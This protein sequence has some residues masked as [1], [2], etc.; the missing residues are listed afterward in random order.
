VVTTGG[1]WRIRKREK[2]PFLEVFR[3]EETGHG[4]ILLP[5]FVDWRTTGLQQQAERSEQLDHSNDKQA[6]PS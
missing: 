3:L 4:D 1:V 5:A 2:V 6:D